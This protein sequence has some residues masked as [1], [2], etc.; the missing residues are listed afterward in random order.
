MATCKECGIE[1]EASESS[2]DFEDEF[3]SGSCQDSY[4]EENAGEEE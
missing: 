2:A 1:Y 4:E 3:C